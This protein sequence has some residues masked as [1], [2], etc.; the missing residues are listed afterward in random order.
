MLLYNVFLV[1]C[2]LIID[3]RSDALLLWQVE[4]CAF[5]P[6]CCL[7]E[8]SLT[9]TLDDPSYYKTYVIC[10]SFKISL[11]CPDYQIIL[12]CFVCIKHH[13]LDDERWEVMQ[14]GMQIAGSLSAM[15]DQH[16]LLR[17]RLIGPRTPRSID[18][19]CPGADK[20]NVDT[21]LICYR[22]SI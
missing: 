10:W 2:Q 20:V 8:S 5:P 3:I 17:P 4:G 19:Y 6:G 9:I 18:S 14:L 1:K 22:F 7:D 13:C 15:F 11:P 16:H 21:P 12:I